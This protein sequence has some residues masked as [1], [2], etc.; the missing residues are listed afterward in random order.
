[1]KDEAL[2]HP[3]R[4]IENSGKLSRTLVMTSSHSVPW[5]ALRGRRGS[6]NKAT[7]KRDTSLA[8]RLSDDRASGED[9][10]SGPH[11]DGDACAVAGGDS[12]WMLDKGH[13]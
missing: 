10:I 2:A 1:M 12:S 7:S 8:T 13:L 9:I 6:G 11:L 5:N 4:R 3:P